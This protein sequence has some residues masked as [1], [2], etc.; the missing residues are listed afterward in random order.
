[1]SKQGPRYKHD[2]DACV[3]LCRW[4]EFDLYFCPPPTTT[5]LARYGDDGHQYASLD[6]GCSR[7]PTRALKDT[8]DIASRT[9]ISALRIAFL[10]AND[11]G[12]IPPQPIPKP[13]DWYADKE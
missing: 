4:E 8:W 1:M 6:V 10:I 11:L 9:R 3:F 5:V 7:N 13:Y 2:C 12:I